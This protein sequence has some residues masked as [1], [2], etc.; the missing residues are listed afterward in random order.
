MRNIENKYSNKLRE[1]RVK[2][3]LT[4]KQVAQYLHMQCEDRLS[5]WEKG[6]AFPSIQN[7]SRLCKLYE[8]KAEELYPEFG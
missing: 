7:L 8:A 1:L 3:N 2:K 4:Q 6:R 5:H